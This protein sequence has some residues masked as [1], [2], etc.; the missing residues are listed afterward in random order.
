MATSKA[1]SC[2]T[3]STI[4]VASENCVT[5][6]YGTTGDCAKIGVIYQ[7]ECQ[8][9][10]ATYIGETGRRLAVRI[11]EHLAGK[12]LGNTRT[13]L[14]KHMTEEHGGN[15][16]DVKCS[17]L[18]CE[19]EIFARK[20]LEAFWISARNPSMNNRNECLSITNDLLPFAPHCELLI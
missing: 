9:C 7:I 8:T 19:T 3:G 18:A 13:P 6:P 12:R 4:S 1:N 10:N 14:G 20:V 15:D 17:I 2:E 11:K 16:F 5:C